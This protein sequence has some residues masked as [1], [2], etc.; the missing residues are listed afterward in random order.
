MSIGYL[1]PHESRFQQVSVP[2]VASFN[3]PTAGLYNF[4]KTE[5][6]NAVSAPPNPRFWVTHPNGVG[7]H[8]Y[9]IDI[10]T[11][12]LWP[13]GQPLRFSTTSALP[14]PLLTNTT[15]YVTG[16]TFYLGSWLTNVSLTLGGPNIVFTTQGVGVHTLTAIHPIM[17]LIRNYLYFIERVNIG[18]TQS[19]E[20][21]QNAMNTIP[22]LTFRR[23]L[24]NQ[25][26]FPKPFPIVNYV[27]NQELNGWLITD[28]DNDSLVCTVTGLL[29]PTVDLIGQDNFAL[30]MQ[31]NI[32]EIQDSEYIKGWKSGRAVVGK[33]T[34]SNQFY[35]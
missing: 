27:S 15:Y 4:T 18:G 7:I 22:I 23:S 24:D 10:S 29:N 13:I 28:R 6:I 35:R 2:L 25:Y 21:F 17:D 19:Q 32:Y 20:I 31:V 34:V 9:E 33:Q 16:S 11:A 5:S 30:N 8:P 3:V 26:V 12:S 1:I 14:A